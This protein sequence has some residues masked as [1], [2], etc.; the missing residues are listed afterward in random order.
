M[1][2]S[3]CN[4]T[5]TGDAQGKGRQQAPVCAA[6]SLARSPAHDGGSR[7][8]L[9]LRPAGESA[10]WVTAKLRRLSGPWRSDTKQPPRHACTTS[11]QRRTAATNAI[12]G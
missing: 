5:S 12:V 4:E 10:P 11:P 1:R 8:P 9:R 6:A 3:V 2:A 7:G